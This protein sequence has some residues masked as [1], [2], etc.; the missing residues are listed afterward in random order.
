MFWNVV[1]QIT[2][3]ISRSPIDFQSP[4]NIQG[5]LDKYENV[6]CK[7]SSFFSDLNW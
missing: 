3:D 4:G 6:V 1:S 5:N 7:M 2:H